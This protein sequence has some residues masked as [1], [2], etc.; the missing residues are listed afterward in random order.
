MCTGVIYWV[1]KNYVTEM[2]LKDKDTLVIKKFNLFLIT[3]TQE[4]NPRDIKLPVDLG[5]SESFRVK[6]EGYLVDESQI[7]DIDL[8]ECIS[9]MR[10]QKEK[11]MEESS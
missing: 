7:Q 4:V 11:K 1:S 9:G 2:Y 6:E 5:F 3:T 10:G 8:Y